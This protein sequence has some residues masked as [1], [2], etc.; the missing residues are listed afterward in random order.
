[1]VVLAGLVNAGFLRDPID[2][3]VPDAIVPA[4]LLMAWIASQAFR[5]TRLAGRAAAAAA[6]AAVLMCAVTVG[7]LQE[8][9]NRAGVSGGLTGVRERAAEV[10]AELR[11]PYAEEQMPTDVA[12]ALVPFYEYVQAC[13]TDDAALFVT[14]FAPE[15]PYYARRRF[16]GGH[17]TLMDDLYDSASDQQLTVDRLRAQNVPFVVIPSGGLDGLT[18][19]FPKI[20]AY[21][22]QQYRSFTDIAVDGADERARVFSRIDLAPTAYYGSDHWPCFR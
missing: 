6:M 11:A 14:G 2:A 7:R 21:V 19:S 5:S 8:Q 9:L 12:F 15:I 1:L 4:V 17:V 22:S 18:R 10:V 13:T 16:A 20:G 3:R